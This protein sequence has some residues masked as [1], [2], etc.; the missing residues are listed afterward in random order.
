MKKLLLFVLTL[1]CF[2]SF[3]EES[4]LERRLRIINERLAEEQETIEYKE[5]KEELINSEEVKKISCFKFVSENMFNNVF[6]FKIDD[7]MFCYV[8]PKKYDVDKKG[9][10]SSWLPQKSTGDK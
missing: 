10:T 3:A 5:A 1:A 2:A 7:K 8:S 6:T 9:F 4:R